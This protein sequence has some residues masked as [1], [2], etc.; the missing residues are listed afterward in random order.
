MIADTRDAPVC[1][2]LNIS[3]P[4][5]NSRKC[6]S[7]AKTDIKTLPLAHVLTAKQ[8]AGI[9]KPTKTLIEEKNAVTT[10]VC[11]QFEASSVLSGK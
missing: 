5:V 1:R 2:Q 11:L 4:P 8:D 9:D 6:R 10:C 7:Q 3:R